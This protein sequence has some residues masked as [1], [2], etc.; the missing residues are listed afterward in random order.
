MK[1]ISVQLATHFSQPGITVAMLWKVI[2]PD[3]VKI[4]FTDNDQAITFNDG[5][6]TVTYYPAEGVTG[7]ATDTSA[8]DT[9]SQ[10]IV[11]FLDSSAITEADIFANRYDYAVIEIRL[12]NWADLSMGA[13]LWKRA[14]L[15]EVKMRNGQFTSELRGL[16]FWLTINMGE[17]YG[18]QCRAD[19]GDAQC[20]IDLSLFIQNGIVE[21][22]SDRRTFV[23]AAAPSATPLV[24][25][26]SA[27]PTA[28]APSGWFNQGVISFTSGDNNGFKIEVLNWDGTTLLLFES[29]PFNIQPGDTFTI[30]PGCDK[31]IST[32]L[33]KFNNLV[34]HRGEPLI[35]GMDQ[36]LI[37]PNSGGGIP[38]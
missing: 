17:A 1:A 6:D 23:P 14:T 8:S 12:V 27:T 2:R 21:T 5:I 19:L 35:P 3:N 16:E 26:G 32:C 18:P 31:L 36:I 13:M 7:S 24:M 25:R 9:S 28:P 34:N 30:E 11:G 15:G 29:L 20:T 33:T 37:Y 22:V 10:D 38:A 4:G